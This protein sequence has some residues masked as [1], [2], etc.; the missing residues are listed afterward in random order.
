MDCCNRGVL[1]NDEQR[2]RPARPDGN[3]LPSVNDANVCEHNTGRS[4]APAPNRAVASHG[5]D[6]K[7]SRTTWLN[8]SGCSRK[9]KWPA[10]SISTLREPLMAT[11]NLSALAGGDI[12]SFAPQTRR[13][14]ALIPR[15]SSS[16]SPPRPLSLALC[17]LS[18]V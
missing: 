1:C 11:F 18:I 16:V 12:L 15:T 4:L 5:F 14:G 9:G 10:L 13:V 17:I 2:I 6:F 3:F 7:N 8:C